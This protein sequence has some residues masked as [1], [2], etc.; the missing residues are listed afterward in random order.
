MS[1]LLQMSDT[2]LLCRCIHVGSR[3]TDLDGEQGVGVQNA[4]DKSEAKGWR[5]R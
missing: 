1:L 5:E 3:P 2:G 4:D